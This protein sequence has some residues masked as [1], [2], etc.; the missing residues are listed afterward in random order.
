MKKSLVLL[1]VLLTTVAFAG[2]ACAFYGWGCYEM[3]TCKIVCKD[4]VLC[5]GSAAGNIALCGP[6]M[7]INGKISCPSVSYKGKWITVLKCPKMK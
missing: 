5:Q 3:P 6:A 4:E 1:V 7:C 2:S